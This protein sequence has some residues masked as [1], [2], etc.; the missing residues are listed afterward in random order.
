MTDRGST[1]ENAGTAPGIT[2]MFR[3]HRHAALALLA[4]V[5]PALAQ[6]EPI[7]FGW[8]AGHWCG[9]Q[10][11]ASIEELWLDRGGELLGLSTSLR[12][13]ELE[14]FEYAHIEA[15]AGGVV[16]VAQ[17]GGGDAVE[18][19]LVDSDAQRVVFANPAHDFPQSV[20]YWRDE[21]GLHAEIAGPGENGDQRVE[22]DY[23]ACAV[24]AAVATRH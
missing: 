5:A 18:F 6:D 7:D 24:D 14:S 4:F 10:D 12:D 1:K 21:A 9:T 22:F 17:P 16:Y 20:S 23:A 2:T 13:G 15:R 11:G 3:L 19:A 8:L